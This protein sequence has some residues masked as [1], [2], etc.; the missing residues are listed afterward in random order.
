MD[1]QQIV[2]ALIGLAALGAIVRWTVCAFRRGK[3]PCTSCASRSCPLRELSPRRRSARR[4]RGDSGS[5][6]C[7]WAAWRVRPDVHRP[8]F[9]RHNS[10]SG[11]FHRTKIF[12]ET[13]RTEAR[14]VLHRIPTSRPDPRSSVP[15]QDEPH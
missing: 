8:L 6:C 4:H 14:P 10:A 2:V 12:P 15:P 5:G 9:L 1:W 11:N 13:A 7:R 3:K